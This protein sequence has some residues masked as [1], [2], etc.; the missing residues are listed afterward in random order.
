LFSQ[1]ADQLWSG[2]VDTEV[3]DPISLVVD[4]SVKLLS[5]AEARAKNFGDPN[6]VRDV[7]PQPTASTPRRVSK[8][9]L[10]GTSLSASQTVTPLTLRRSASA[11]LGGVEE[12]SPAAASSIGSGRGAVELVEARGATLEASS[13]VMQLDDAALGGLAGEDAKDDDEDEDPGSYNTA[14]EKWSHVH[15][16]Q[17]V[18]LSCKLNIRMTQFAEEALKV[19]TKTD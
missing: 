4:P 5:L 11:L 10:Q 3:K 9:A 15:S 16:L 17:K 12:D 2:C 6:D 14:F 18:L 1:H 8:A 7:L 19:M 13:D